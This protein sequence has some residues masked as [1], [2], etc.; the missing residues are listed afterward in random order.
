VDQRRDAACPR[1][2]QNVRH[3]F[4]FGGV[5]YG[6][7]AIVEVVEL[8]PRPRLQDLEVGKLSGVPTELLEEVRML[9]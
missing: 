6:D 9:S 7:G 1:F 8:S 3:A 5:D 4:E 2:E